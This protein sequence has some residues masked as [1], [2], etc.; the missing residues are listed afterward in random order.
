MRSWPN[1]MPTGS[2]LSGRRVLVTR[3][4]HQ[5]EGL[6]QRILAHGG[7]PLCLPTL[8]IIDLASSPAVQ[9]ALGQLGQYQLLIFV[10]PNAVHCGLNV[11]DAAGG[12][13]PQVLLAT[14]GEG[15]ARTL[16]ERL[17]RGPDLVPRDSF[18]SEGLLALPALQQVAGQRIL[19]LRGEDGR[20]LLAETLRQRGAQVD[21]LAVYRR[22]CPPLPSSLDDWP[23]NTDIITVTSG[24]GLR[25]LYQMTPD[26]QRSA[27]L[28]R[29]M[30]VVSSRTAA[31]AAELGFVQPAWLAHP[32]SDDA[33]VASL[34][35]WAS[36][37]GSTV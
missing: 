14:V 33:I 6:C 10:S 34:I 27:M 12:L 15:S 30:V 8:A 18:D 7:Q 9:Q 32:A 22:E 31:L 2:E 3:P 19:I 28:A 1:C 26:A 5:A 29:P 37:Q 25:N 4:A 13:P 16:R 36:T 11:L 24:E 20:N 17:G 23:Q 21:Y 35:E